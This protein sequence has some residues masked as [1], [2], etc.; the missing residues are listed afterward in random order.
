MGVVDSKLVKAWTHHR[1][2]LAHGKTGS[3]QDDVEAFHVA[4]NAF[5]SVALAI[6]RFEG[7]FRG[8]DML[9]GHELTAKSPTSNPFRARPAWAR[10]LHRARLAH[11][12]SESPWAWRREHSKRSFDARGLQ[13]E[14]DAVH[15]AAC[16]EGACSLKKRSGFCSEFR[17]KRV[18]LIKQPISRWGRGSCTLRSNI[19]GGQY[20]KVV[21]GKRGT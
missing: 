19:V 6:V 16:E 2:R 1:P 18:R 8:F 13:V 17:S 3:W 5:H 14:S 7:P 9:G 15:L 4:I 21:L 20:F 10:T 11:P 12:S